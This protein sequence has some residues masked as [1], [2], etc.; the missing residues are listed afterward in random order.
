[1]SNK[2]DT[3]TQVLNYINSKTKD[4]Y[5]MWI[6]KDGYTWM[7]PNYHQLIKKE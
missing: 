2:K 6:D 7:F 5:I 1:M 3:L 4:D